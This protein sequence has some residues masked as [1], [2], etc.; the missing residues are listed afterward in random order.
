MTTVSAFER[1]RWRG[2]GHLYSQA[3]RFTEKYRA[4]GEKRTIVHSSVPTED[5]IQQRKV[6]VREHGFF[7]RVQTFARKMFFPRK[8]G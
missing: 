1:Y 4:D 5:V 6:P 2:H 8:T 3:H 7:K